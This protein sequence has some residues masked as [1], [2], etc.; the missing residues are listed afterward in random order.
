MCPQ[1][2]A[3]LYPIAQLREPF[4]SIQ[5]VAERCRLPECLH[6]RLPSDYESWSAFLIC[7]GKSA[8]PL[9][10]TRLHPSQ[11]YHVS[12][13]RLSC[14]GC[15]SGTRFSSPATWYPAWCMWWWP[16]IPAWVQDFNHDVQLLMS[17]CAV[18]YVI[19]M[20][21]RIVNVQGQ[22]FTNVSWPP[23]VCLSFQDRAAGN[24]GQKS[25]HSRFMLQ[26]PQGRIQVN[27]TDVPAS[28]KKSASTIFF[29]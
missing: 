24:R 27:A 13:W 14:Y 11:L 8:F 12:S 25:G 6:L 4:S 29:S 16:R 20:S 18:V 5:Y 15:E 10:I 23:A 17:Y 1:V 28:V 19:D 3:G 26:V 22:H 2:L 9:P 7:D 21:V